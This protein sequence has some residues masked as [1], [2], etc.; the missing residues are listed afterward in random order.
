MSLRASLQG[1]GG[2]GRGESGVRRVLADGDD[3]S[4]GCR[5]RRRD[6]CLCGSRSR[7]T[8]PSCRFQSGGAAR[9]Y[10]GTARAVARAAN[11]RSLPVRQRGP[12]GG[13]DGRQE[14]SLSRLLAEDHCAPRSRHWSLL[15]AR[16]GRLRRDHASARNSRCADSA[17]AGA[18]CIGPNDA[19]P[20]P[21]R[22][23]SPRGCSKGRR[24]NALSQLLAVYRHPA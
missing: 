5:H 20:L 19:G 15:H 23:R 7:S 17:G 16:R 10:D 8:R 1:P 12:R 6:A 4:E 2:A 18:V 13:R 3:P 9:G 22:Q 11:P 24:E 14:H 21:M